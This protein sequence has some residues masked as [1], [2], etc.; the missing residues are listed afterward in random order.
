MANPT[1]TLLASVNMLRAL[2]LPRF[3]DMIFK[4]LW[5][6]YDEGKY[7]THDVG[8]NATMTQFTDRLLKEVT[9]LDKLKNF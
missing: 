5:N 8:G 9:E 3:G 2:N 1:S 4:G 6:V 7:L